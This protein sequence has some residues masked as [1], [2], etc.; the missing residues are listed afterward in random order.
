MSDDTT[1]RV[2]ATGDVS[3]A[4]KAMGTLG[5]SVDKAGKK[6][7][8][9][10]VLGGAAGAAAG[11]LF[12]E[13]MSKG[14]ELQT[15]TA[16]ISAQLGYTGAGAQ[17]LGQVAGNLYASGFGDT[18]GA[19]AADLR[20]VLQSGIID[21]DATQAE[22]QAVASQV[23]QLSDVMDQDLG[24]TT[25]AVSQMLRTGLAGSATEAMDVLTR[26]IQQGADKAGDLMDT[27]NEYGTQFRKIGLDGATAMGLLTQGLNAGA[28]DSDIVADALKE[29]SIRSMEA[30]EKLDSKGRPQ[31]TALGAAFQQVGLDGY[32]AQ[33]DLGKGGASAA[34]VLD[35]VMDGL[36]GIEDPTQR[37]QAAVALFGTQAE[38]MGAAL[39][40]LDPSKAVSYMGNIEGATAKTGAAY[41]TA[42]AKIDG[43]KRSFELSAAGAAQSSGAMGLL[44]TGVLEFGGPALA[45]GG[46]I[47]ALITGMSALNLGLVVEKGSLLASAAAKG[48]SSAATGIATA[49]QWAWN[50]A[51]TA[52][53]IGIVIVAIAALVAGLVWFFTKTE[54]GRKVWAAAMLAMSA[55]IQ[56]LK[57]SAS[58]AIQWISDKWDGMVNLFRTAPGK[59][60]G[61]LRGMF[62]GLRD[63]FR[64]AI[65]YII[66][67]WNR[68]S[69]GIPGFSFAGVSVPGMTVSVPK[70]PMLAA[71]GIV[72]KPTLALIGE[73]GP[74]AVV[75]LTGGMSS[76]GAVGGGQVVNVYVTQPLGTPDAI[77]RAVRDA[78]ARSGNRGYGF[79]GA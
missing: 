40:A 42:A 17:E 37:A 78:L 67:G 8:G 70:I 12:A 22:M 66:A 49:A 32:Q 18:V 47:G 13:G 19:A 68:L 52:N 43:I 31:L 35:K 54:T 5:D 14:M 59:V 73:A 74:E 56:W 38:D 24:A 29:F 23:M 11:G 60:S 58:T 79:G 4:T 30:I 51:L 45:M 27:V 7:D 3:D 62:N 39:Y 6:L 9:L 1:L 33:A 72:T 20:T 63:G 76:V 21:E 77:G 10:K 36:R 46:Q 28:R 65:N 16:K 26:G 25:N 64:S 53:P 34:A 75:P 48:I 61:A 2:K 41:D 44:T 69:F 50:A 55:G 15:A 71:G 57:A